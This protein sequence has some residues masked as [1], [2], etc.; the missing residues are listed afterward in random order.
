MSRDLGWKRVFLAADGRVRSGWRVL[1]FVAL[2]AVAWTLAASL[3]AVLGLPVPT[4]VRL[5]APDELF[6]PG[7]ASLAAAL[8]AGWIMLAWLEDRPPGALGF[9]W[10]SRTLRELG[11]GLAIGGGFLALVVGLLA[12]V[13][14]VRYAPEAGTAA[15][16]AAVLL[17]HL[18]MLS[19]P[20]AAEEA[21]FRGYPFQVLVEGIGA[22]A[23]TVLL[24]AAFALA[25]LGNEG[26]GAFALVNIF[27]AGV[28]LSVA[29]LRTRSLWFATA[30]HLGWNWVMASVLDLP[31]SGL[32]VFDTPLYEPV[33]RGPDWA[34]GGA[35]G[36]EAGI[37]ATVASL[38]AL[39]AVLRVPGL[40]E[41]QEMR[42]FRPIVDRRLGPHGPPP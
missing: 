1:L 41:P 27:L 14:W 2:L 25:H 29:Y 17:N 22:V 37:A 31:V 16:Y 34:T 42:E 28:L 21:L 7:V 19:A 4:D 8:G 10:T 38:A 35:F 23:A 36:P 9:A 15:G 20:A 12:L 39:A 33:I 24:S 6:W 26:V 3:I 30:V 18:V 5:E 13:G 11:L 40:R 32:H